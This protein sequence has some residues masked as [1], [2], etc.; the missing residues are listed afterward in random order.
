M[1]IKYN[2]SFTSKRKL[3]NIAVKNYQFAG[4]SLQDFVEKCYR[5]V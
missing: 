3:I 5:A 1:D 4:S 2:N